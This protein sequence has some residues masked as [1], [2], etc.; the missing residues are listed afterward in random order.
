M[1]LLY[2]FAV[3]FDCYIDSDRLV[4]ISTAYLSEV[5]T[6]TDVG[7]SKRIFLPLLLCSWYIDSVYTEQ[8]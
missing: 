3:C 1:F 4:D 7:F 6:F 5:C 8:C 2:V